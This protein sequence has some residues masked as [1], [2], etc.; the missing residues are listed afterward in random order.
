M[1]K[2]AE[3]LQE[4]VLL[5]DGA[6]GTMLYEA[7]VFLN[8]CF[9]ELNLTRPELVRHIHEAYVRAGV[10]FIETNT[11]GASA[12]K[13][14][15][16]GLADQVGPINEAAA[17]LARQAAGQAVGRTVL[18]AGAMGPLG[19]ALPP[20]GQYDPQVAHDAFGQQARI[21]SQA[22]VDFFLLETFSQ[23]EELLLAIE[24]VHQAAP[25]AAIVA[26]LTTDQHQETLYG[27]RLDQAIQRLAEREAVT[28]LGLNCSVG[29]S[30]M[31]RS[32]ELIRPLTD[33]PISVQPNAGLPRQ[34]EGRK[35]Y[36]CTPEY[37]AEY[38]K[39]F[40]EKGAR[41]IGGCCGTSPD[42]IRQIVKAV[43]SL[44]RA[45]AGGAGRVTAGAVRAAP[46]E[47]AAIQVAQEAAQQ[48]AA[49]L[50]EKSR[51][52]A[53]LAAGQPVST[54]ELT[55]PR[56]FDLAGVLEKAR[57]CARYGI[58][59][60][61]IP[62]GP[63]ASSRL[64]PLV[65]ALKIRQE[66]DIEPILHVCCRDRNLIG[67]QSDMLGAYATGLRNVLI[68]TGD[69]PKLGEY[70]DAT[71]V[72]DLDSIGLTRVVRDLNRGLDIA[73]NPFAPPLGLTIGVG[74]NPVALDIQREIDRFAGKV[75][76][77]AEYA[78][79]QPVFD[80]GML[81][82]FLDQIGSPRAIPIVAGIWPF[83]SYKNAEFMA[84]EVPGVVVPEPLLERMRHTRTRAEG[85][86][87]GIEIAREM[88]EAVRDR[89]AGFAVSAPFGNVRIALAVLGLI[90]EKEIDEC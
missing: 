86:R 28:A 20:Y 37:M 85:R 6:M 76:A 82:A 65:T 47:T 67:L 90:D 42:H 56:G 29:P 87:Q 25:E 63:R 43:R 7:G 4:R 62:D 40:F 23:V 81:E 74:A 41:I 54:I 70:P 14:A 39:R 33:K 3:R 64:S 84:N 34:V 83:T 5:G 11:F 12:A 46:A 10:D 1:N 69:P 77:G 8:T 32:L 57:L 49:P 59:A 26:Q 44:E 68:I 48:A 45:Q 2:L 17:A 53:K 21:L 66:V 73:G 27:E 52:G 50:A 9:D 55:P 78:I 89:V 71:A 18:V 22:G 51:F 16:Y 24:A 30:A 88:I 58:D 35:L 75:A 19:V 13:L 36:M 61:N 80:P 72:F 60:I 15:A 79:T 31:L 38:A